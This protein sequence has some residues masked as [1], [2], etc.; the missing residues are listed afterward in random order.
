[1]AYT[2]IDNV[3]LDLE[4]KVLIDLT[5]DNDNGIVDEN[6]VNRQIKK[7][8]DTIDIYMRGRYPV[9]GD[10][11]TP[12]YLVTLSTQLTI[13]YLYQR[14]QR[15]VGNASIQDIYDRSIMMLK[16]IQKGEATPFEKEDEPAVIV[17]NKDATSKTFTKSLLDRML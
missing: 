15:D 12:E 7:A 3:K 2:T 6:V 11:T 8:D 5:D 9:D 17:S 16:E 4:E 14:K 10:V 1:M 13:Y